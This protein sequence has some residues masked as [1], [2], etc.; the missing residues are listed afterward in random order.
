MIHFRILIPCR[1]LRGYTRLFESTRENRTTTPK[2]WRM[3]RLYY[4]GRAEG[5]A[6]F[7]HLDYSAG[8][9]QHT[10]NCP[11]GSRVGAVL[12]VRYRVANRVGPCIPDRAVSK[13]VTD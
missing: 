3:P 6:L 2:F 4:I 10:D 12:R 5:T 7:V 8:I 1:K 9:V 13:H 11:L